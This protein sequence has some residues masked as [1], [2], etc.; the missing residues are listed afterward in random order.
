MNEQQDAGLIDGLITVLR[1]HPVTTV[2][3]AG[4][5]VVAFVGVAF[6]LTSPAAIHAVVE[7]GVR[8]IEAVGPMAT[9]GTV[10]APS[11]LG[12]VADGILDKL[13]GR[14]EK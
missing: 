2:V 11:L 9:A 10:V 13:A 8:F 5:V 6:A 3:T 1:E 4:E 14:G 12:L 7:M